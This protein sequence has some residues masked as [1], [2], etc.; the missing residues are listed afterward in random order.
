M[1]P[2]Y[3]EFSIVPGPSSAWKPRFAYCSHKATNEPNKEGDLRPAIDPKPPDDDLKQPNSTLE[4]TLGA[5][6]T[7]RHVPWRDPRKLRSSA[8]FRLGAT[9]GTRRFQFQFAGKRIRPW[10]RDKRRL[11]PG[12]CK[13]PRERWHIRQWLGLLC[14]LH[15]Q[16]GLRL[17]GQRV[18]AGGK[19][20]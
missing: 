9:R 6:M 1:P 13:P 2:P 10:P 12:T 17:Q 16:R 11:Q 20:I 3:A 7:M 14:R 5:A 4:S 8:P 18:Q 15:L 19:F